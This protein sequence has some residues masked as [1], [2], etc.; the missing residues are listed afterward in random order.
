MYRRQLIRKEPMLSTIASLTSLKYRLILCGLIVTAFIGYVFS[1]LGFAR[2]RGFK[3]DFYAAMYDPKWWNGEGIFYG[4]IFVFERWFVNLFPT[5]ATV[6]FFAVGCLFFIFVSLIITLNIIKTS[7]YLNVYCLIT[8]A[9]NTFLYYS[10][11]VAANPELLELFLLLI[12]WWCFAKKRFALGSVAFTCAVLTKLSPIIFLPILLI[13]FSW[14]SAILSV[15]LF[16]AIVLVVSIGQKQNFFTSISQ[17]LDVETAGLQPASEQFL[18]LSSGLARL[19]GMQPDE[20]FKYVILLASVLTCFLFTISVV[21]S[22]KIYRSEQIPSYDVK[23][24]Y[25]FAL[26]LTLLPF[27]HF[28]Q[29]H[30]HTYLFLAP[31]FVALKFIF[32]SDYEIARGL[33]Y[34]RIIDLLFLIY[35]FLPIYFLDFTNVNL[36]SGVSFGSDFGKSFAMLSEPVWTNL[37]L[38]VLIL[39]YGVGLCKKRSILIEEKG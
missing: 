30:R 21:V 35:T 29:T 9:L 27:F 23:V 39:V 24:A 36:L 32:I 8:W 14:T 25:I 10:F 18:G 34:S 38:L 26:F 2:P 17:M 15:A 16:I 28:S 22:V 20:N 31:V 6:Q 3:G 5:F 33:H 7:R 13:F 12:M 4:P 19:L 1:Y 11:S 37:A